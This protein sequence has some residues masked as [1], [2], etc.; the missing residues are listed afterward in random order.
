MM[1]KI[2]QVL[3]SSNLDAM[4]DVTSNYFK[5]YV[6]L[7]NNFPSVIQAIKLRSWWHKNDFESFIGQGKNTDD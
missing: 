3:N 4:P 7:G 2:S 1:N 5:F 6:G